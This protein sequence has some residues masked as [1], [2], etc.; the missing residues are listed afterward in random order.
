MHMQRQKEILFFTE[1][2]LNLYANKLSFGAFLRTNYQNIIASMSC[3]HTAMLC[4][5][6]LKDS[7]K[8]TKFL[9][10]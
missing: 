5:I 3:V 7:V 8:V 2:Q 1:E 6:Y 10:L 9:K 4:T